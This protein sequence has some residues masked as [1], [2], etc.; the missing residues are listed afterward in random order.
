MRLNQLACASFL[1]ITAAAGC[2]TEQDNLSTGSHS[3]VVDNRISFNRISFNRISFNRISFNRISFNRIINF[4]TASDLLD[5]P[6][7]RELFSFIVS[8]AIPEGTVLTAHNPNTN[9]D[10]T[11]L[12]EVGLAPA[13]QNR[14][15]NASERRWVSAC[16]LARVNNNDVTVQI[17]MRGPNDELTADPTEK[18][19]FSLEEGAFFG[20][21]F[22]DPTG[23][24][25]AYACRGRGQAA[26]EPATGALADRDCTEP[27]PA[28]PG[29]TLCGMFY[30]GDCADFDPPAND[31]ACRAQDA[32][33]G[34][35]TDCATSSI[36]YDDDDDDD[37]GHGHGGHGHGGHGWGWGHGGWGHHGGHRS[38]G[39][40]NAHGHSGY[41]HDGAFCDHGGDDH[42]DDTTAEVITTFLRP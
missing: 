33:D 42:D 31:Y 25:Q 22:T 5:T 7:D 36:F 3:V 34:F 16:L 38:H 21:I 11:F 37:H 4:D 35:Y 14:A 10:F 8:C 1:L 6:E 30:A 20:D 2:A 15:L 28:N 18:T 9:E 29:K 24:I 23:D 13:W 40:E 19:T 12:G 17:S 26:G 41:G 39:H 27:D 32:D